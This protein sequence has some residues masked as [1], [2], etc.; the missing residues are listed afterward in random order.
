[1]GDTLPHAAG[2]PGTR[3]RILKVEGRGELEVG[4]L[5][6]VV[7]HDTMDGGGT[8][9]FVSRLEGGKGTMVT[10]FSMNLAE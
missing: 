6:L 3:V 4:E 9:S 5:F 2:D 1:M 10:G 7:Q 8:G